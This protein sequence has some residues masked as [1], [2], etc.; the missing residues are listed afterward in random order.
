MW[1]HRNDIVHERTEEWLTKKESR[2]LELDII[3]T[4]LDGNSQVLPQHQNMFSED[5]EHI[6]N[7]TVAEKKYWLLTVQA[8][9]E[10]YHVQHTHENDTNDARSIERQFATVPD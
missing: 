3:R 4:Y 5:V 2:A 7:R 1:N 8:I 6:L 9:R 10:C